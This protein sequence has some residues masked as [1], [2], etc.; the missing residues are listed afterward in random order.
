M[1]TSSALSAGTVVWVPCELKSGIFPT[2]HH[3][4]IEVNVGDTETIFGFIPKE[5][6]RPSEGDP[7]HGLVRAV[8]LQTINGKVVIVLRGEI[9]SRSNPLIVPKE[10][11]EAVG[12][13]EG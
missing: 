12:Q 3:V 9:L 8:V 6:V 13:R 7:E 10:W 11:I 4:K 2:E 1:S 5:D